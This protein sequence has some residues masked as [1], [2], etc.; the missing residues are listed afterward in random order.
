M[1]Q[2][3]LTFMEMTMRKTILYAFAIPALLL[4]A[5]SPSTAAAPTLAY[6]V[7]IDTAAPAANPAQAYPAATEAIPAPGEQATLTQP[8]APTEPV[9]PT[10]AAAAPT[11]AAAEASAST[12]SRVTFNLPQGV[13]TGAR[14]DLQPAV[15][16]QQDSP[17]WTARPA[18][19][20]VRLQGYPLSNTFHT[21]AIRVYPVAAFAQANPDAQKEIDALKALLANPAALP[22]KIPM[23]PMFNA[24]QVFHAGVKPL[25]FQ[26]GAGV[27]F[28]TQYDQAVV[29]INNKELFYTFQGLTTDGQYYISAILPVSL[30]ALPADDQFTA[31]E[32][33]KLAKD[34]DSYLKTTVQSLEA[35][36]A[37]DY[38]PSLDALDT[39]IASLAVNPGDAFSKPSTEMAPTGLWRV[40]TNFP[41]P[42]SAMSAE[43]IDA[44]SKET[45]DIRA[46]QIT[47][48]GQSCPVS[49]FSIESK[50][51]AQYFQ[52]M[53]KTDAQL[54]TVGTAPIEVIKTDCTLPGLSE[55]VRT[56]N[57]DLIVNVDGVFFLLGIE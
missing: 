50:D 44:L 14:T 11:T 35:A 42:V 46:D 2:G 39:L 55:F 3:N 9:A 41:G 45:L 25:T 5:C 17:Y 30:A 8:A 27:R 51:G 32:V 36:P 23:I 24:A 40:A 31:D 1:I 54:L 6:P 12:D 10:N 53:Y 19:L 48:Q 16:A 22:D 13:A 20:D 28:L 57:D 15:P 18:M 4:S 21:P 56:A 37:G 26:N 52:D 7:V 43:Q 38:S 47:F 33:E 49:S 34:F 29:P